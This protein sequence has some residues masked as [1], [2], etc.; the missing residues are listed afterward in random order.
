MLQN[1]R[2]NAQSSIAKGI[3]A[4][5]IVPFVFF[6]IDSFFTGGGVKNI[7]EVNGVEISERELLI[8][9]ENQKR[10]LQSQMGEAYDPTVISDAFLKPQVLESLV[11][12]Q[13]YQDTTEDLD[14]V[15]SEELLDARIVASP[16]FQENGQFSA[17]RY[18]G[19]LRANGMMP[20][21]HRQQLRT[22]IT[23]NH[24][25]SGFAQ[26]EFATDADVRVTAKVTHQR[27]DVRYITVPAVNAADVEA[28][29]D[30]AVK[31]YY[32]DN[33]LNYMKDDE[34]QLDFIEL[35]L[36]DFNVDVSEE[37]VRETYEREKAAYE[38][39]VEW[40]VAH[41]LAEINDESSRDDAS[42]KIA[43]AQQ[44]LADGVDF[45]EVAASYS[46]DSGSSGSGG[47][48]GSFGP[49]IFP[50]FDEALSGLDS[51]QVS[52][53]V[54]TESGL[55]LLKLLATTESE[56]PA[57]E[58]S[59][60]RIAQELQ[61]SRATPEYISRIEE[62]EDATF[63]ADDLQLA[64]EEFQLPVQTTAF[65]S[66]AEGQG[67]AAYPALRNYA[68]S[69]EFLAQEQNSEKIELGENR[70]AIVRL[71]EFRESQPR[72]LI[73]V[74]EQIR[75]NLHA[76]A[77]AQASTDKANSALDAVAKQESVEAAAKSLGL[78]WQVQLQ[79]ERNSLTV[80]R[81]ILDAAFSEENFSDGKALTIANLNNGDR[82]VVQVSNVQAGTLPSLASNDKAALKS[83]L[84]QMFGG[85][86]FDDFFKAIRDKASVVTL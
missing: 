72:P 32:D 68:F 48:L 43:K 16:E 67:I 5:M 46:D 81:A 17:E 2:D 34:I 28:I 59:R 31:E 63:G 25:I 69:D 4:L 84:S 62:L 70:V 56:F 51:A 14:L 35:K 82:A 7:A 65:F 79:A 29:T 50:E 80:E 41:I 78:D 38:P 45:A 3:V 37:E 71:K 42:A 26:S 40:Q 75:T 10:R 33:Q 1:I 64:A 86:S 24:L 53:V 74:A 23:A 61:G 54:E 60:E 49:G 20:S 21:D 22:Q 47:E 6:G 76:D 85:R 73:E 55:H 58:Q 18:E 19:L 36:S 57:F 13:L 44:A 9:I 11:Q 27:R 8:G 52:D 39:D 30:E 77:V 15:A 66:K 83:S 12:R